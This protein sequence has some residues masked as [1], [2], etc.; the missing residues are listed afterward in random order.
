MA[1]CWLR[2]AL[3]ARPQ[4]LW[5]RTGHGANADYILVPA[6]TLVHLYEALS[7][8]VGTAISCDTG[9]A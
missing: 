5:R 3:S 4:D 2:A 8:E 7:F 9:I 6:R 1:L